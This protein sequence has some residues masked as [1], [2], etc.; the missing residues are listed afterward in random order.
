MDQELQSIVF[1]LLKNKDKTSVAEIQMG[2]CITYSAALK[3]MNELKNIGAVERKYYGV[4][5]LINK[6]MVNAQKLNE[7]D[8]DWLAYDISEKESATLILMCGQRKRTE[9][10]DLNGFKE[11]LESLKERGLIYEFDGE[12][13]LQLNKSEVEYVSRRRIR[14]RE[15]T[16]YYIVAPM[17]N[18]VLDGGNVEVTV[19]LKESVIIPEANNLSLKRIINALTSPLAKKQDNVKE[20]SQEIKRMTV[21]TVMKRIYEA[22]EDGEISHVEY[23]RREIDKISDVP[24]LEKYRT[25]L[26]NACKKLEGAKT[27]D[28][29]NEIILAEGF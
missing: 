8:L 7:C 10:L 25:F 13:V 29:I 4:Y 15:V 18:W 20:P 11:Q 23:L 27:E 26:F 3:I 17:I 16:K 14:F 24:F 9:K 28:E 2:L 1:K 12:S 5:S 6:R 21:Q 22:N 19:P